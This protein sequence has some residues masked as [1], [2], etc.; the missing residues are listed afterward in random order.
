MR[1]RRRRERTKQRRD[2]AKRAR[3][4]RRFAAT[5]G[6]GVGTALGM[7]ATAQAAVDTITVTVLGDGGG[8]GDCSTQPND[9]TLREAITDSL[10]GDAPDVDRIVFQSGLSGEITLGSELPM[11][12]EPLTIAGPETATL[13][14]DGNDATRLF[15]IN[16][17]PGDQ[18]LIDNLTLR[19]GKT[20]SSSQSGGAILKKNANLTLVDDV[21]TG[22]DVSGSSSDGGAVASYGTA[23]PEQGSLT[24]WRSTFTTNTTSGT[25]TDGG[26]IY[27]SS[28][29]VRITDS[30][31]S[32]NS[33]HV[34]GGAYIAGST[35][36][37]QTEIAGT[38][39]SGNHSTSPTAINT[40]AGGGLYLGYGTKLIDNSTITGNTSTGGSSGS[41]F[42]GGISSY[43]GALIIDSSTITGNT[44]TGG[45]GA[46]SR[47]GG[48]YSFNND[49]QPQ[50]TNTIVAGNSV[51]GGTTPLGPE[52]QS[53]NDT[54]QVAFSL[55][56]GAASPAINP[57]VPGSNIT[58]VSPQLGA[59]AAN[60]GLTM[61][62]KPAV[63]S[64]VVDAGLT[65][66]SDDQR[67]LPRPFDSPAIANST[68]PGNGA[69]I[70]A[71]ELQSGD[72]SSPQTCAGKPAT[73]EGKGGTIFGTNGPDVIV[74]TAGANL[75]KGK[76]GKDLICAGKGKDK[77]IGG[78][79]NDTL[80]GQAGN[81]TLKGGGGKDKLKGGAGR[82]KLLG[83]AGKDKLLGGPGKDTQRQ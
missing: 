34:G 33:S 52:L 67:D 6:L 23:D 70:G 75:I 50:I 64:P 30:T 4:R 78:G 77:V 36:G 56:Q 74:G 43:R 44:A 79:G 41:G 51:S 18:V 59:L 45:G 35:N 25:T 40:G 26:A 11:I 68:A 82:D 32:G 29:E 12:D 81:D 69:D 22:N 17:S 48:I 54:F 42:G 73:I 65:M 20:T 83:G 7:G 8:D 31:I 39:I 71:V 28:D 80:L 47:G 5:A 21:F 15:Y 27:S 13:A 57:T 55:I 16:T 66:T 76:G 1:A 24:I 58:G 53:S 2:E 63:T 60:G 10:D 46:G 61:T 38:T 3:A 72:F 14:V 37:H 49:S 19:N 62:R 9:C